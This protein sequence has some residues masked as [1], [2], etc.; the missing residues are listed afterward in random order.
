MN[1]KNLAKIE[2]PREK[3]AKYGPTK[4]SNHELLAIILRTGNRDWGVLDLSQ[5]LLKEF[6]GEKLIHVSVS[7][8]KNVFGLGLVK[9]CEIVATLELGK[10]LF[11]SK[12]YA[13]LL[14][15]QD[16][17]N[18]LRDIREHKKEH[19]IAFYLDSRNQEMK[20]EVISIGTLNENLI[21]PREVFEPA[22]QH[23]AAHIIIAHNHPSGNP[24]PSVEDIEVTKR[25]VQAGKILGIGLLDHIVVSKTG[26]TSLKEKGFL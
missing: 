17:W 25:L 7:E 24:E 20:R 9:A 10:R 8:L 2:M 15:A 6:D 11:Q 26:F 16:V 22:V 13:L 21:H 12:P 3:L 19:L 18:E 23:S 5:K 4:L 14:T 1:I